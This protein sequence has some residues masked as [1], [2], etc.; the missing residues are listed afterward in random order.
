M[1]SCGLFKIQV[2]PSCLI[3][4]IEWLCTNY[5]ISIVIIDCFFLPL[6]RTLLVYTSCIPCELLFLI[7]DL[8][9]HHLLIFR[10]KK[11]DL[12]ADIQRKIV[13]NN[14]SYNLLLM[15]II[16][17]KNLMNKVTS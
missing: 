12:H 9:Y 4:F 3:D 8:I 16:E 13:L 6:R 17:I 5:Y 14:E 7:G 2:S 1:W 11:K 10:K 15:C